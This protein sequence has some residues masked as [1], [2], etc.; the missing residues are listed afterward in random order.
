MDRAERSAWPLG[1]SEAEAK[2]NRGVDRV[3]VEVAVRQATIDL[4]EH[5]SGIGIKFL[6]KLP[7]DGEGK[8]AERPMAVRERRGVGA[9]DGCAKGGLV[10]MI[11]SADHI[12]I[13]SDGVIHSSPE[14]MEQL[15]AGIES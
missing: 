11:I 7:I 13:V 1:F 3:A 4:R 8:G 5:E 12:L 2:P 6:R 15:I 14:D 9:V 10:V